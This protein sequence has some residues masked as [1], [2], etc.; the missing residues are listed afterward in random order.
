MAFGS[1]AISQCCDG[2]DDGRHPLEGIRTIEAIHKNIGINGHGRKGP[3]FASHA[4][5]R[6]ASM[7]VPVL[8][9]FLPD[10][11]RVAA[12]AQWLDQIA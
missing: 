9:K 10:A 7:A 3:L 2:F 12:D 8:L 4:V 11:P 6:K 5:F 1:L